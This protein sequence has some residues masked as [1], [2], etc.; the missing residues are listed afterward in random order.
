MSKKFLR[1]T[2]VSK[3][4]RAIAERNAEK[5]VVKKAQNLSYKEPKSKYEKQLEDL[6][7]NRK[8]FY[9]LSEEE[10]E[11][12]QKRLEIKNRISYWRSA[13]AFEDNN[14]NKNAFFR[15]KETKAYINWKKQW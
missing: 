11:K 5:T 9:E 8:K 6:A 1:I 2:T 15:G 14:P 7:L 3:H 10:Q 4:N 12:E 13:E